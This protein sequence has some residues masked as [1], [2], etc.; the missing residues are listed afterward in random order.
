MLAT[1]ANCFFV[2]HP[3][4]QDKTKENPVPCLVVIRRTAKMLNLYIR[5][6]FNEN[7]LFSAFHI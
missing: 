5:K 2:H 7:S 4:N 3:G 6:M 1:E